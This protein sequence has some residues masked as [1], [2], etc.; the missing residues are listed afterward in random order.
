MV[1]VMDNYTRILL[2]MITVLLTL[3]AIPLWTE[4]AEM[5]S[6]V[7]AAALTRQGIPDSGQQL[8]DLIIQT[9][10]NN[11]TLEEIA[12]ILS[13]DTIKVEIADKTEKS[14]PASQ[15]SNGKVTFIAK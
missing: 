9:E 14:V 2:T 12:R 3:I 6:P 5:N 1:V 13:K 8:N 11:V 7:N 4:N 15:L 10:R